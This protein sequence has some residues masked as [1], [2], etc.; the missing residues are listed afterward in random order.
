MRAAILTLLLASPAA[1]KYRISESGAFAAAGGFAERH[2]WRS[3]S[4]KFSFDLDLPARALSE[5]S[6]IELRVELKDGRSWKARCRASDGSLSAN[7]NALIG[8]GVSVMS[9]CQLQPSGFAK[10]VG[11][12]ASEVGRPILVFHAMVEGGGARAGQQ[13][14][15]LLVPAGRMAAGLVPYVSRDGDPSELAV[16]FVPEAR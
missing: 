15:I 3:Y 2:G 7:V 10:A 11:A 14:G 4:V 8:K 12:K 9:E 16:L 6:S 5:R 1:A 13:K